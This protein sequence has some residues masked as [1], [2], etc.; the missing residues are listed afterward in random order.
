[1]RKQLQIPSVQMATYFVAYSS[2]HVFVYMQKHSHLNHRMF[3]LLHC[4]LQQNGFAAPAHGANGTTSTTANG[5]SNTSG[6]ST[7]M[8]KGMPPPPYAVNFAPELLLIIRESKYLDR[9]GFQVA[10][11]N[12]IT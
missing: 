5:T 9:M 4:T 6:N 11:S 12:N 3:L 1:M 8:F 7:A 10:Y 2:A